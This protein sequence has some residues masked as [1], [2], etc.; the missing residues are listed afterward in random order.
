[1]VSGMGRD[2]SRKEKIPT[3]ATFK[4]MIGHT[5]L[6][7]Y[8]AP[9]FVCFSVVCWDEGWTLWRETSREDGCSFAAA[10][11]VVSPVTQGLSFLM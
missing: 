2:V 11:L 7:V 3:T 4:I 9:D 10:L 5:Q 8:T 6:L 1:M